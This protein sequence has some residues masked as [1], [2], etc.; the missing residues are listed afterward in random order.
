MAQKKDSQPVAVHD[1]DWNQPLSD[2]ELLGFV[3][4]HYKAAKQRRMSW[5]IGA[6]TQLAWARGDQHLRWDADMKDLVE[7]SLWM[8]E[9]IPMEHR[10][11]VALNTI[12]GQVLQKMAL[13]VSRPVTWRSRP[14][15]GD[16]ADLAAARLTTQLLQYNW[17][18]SECP[19]AGVRLMR[20]LWTMFCTG[21]IFA[22]PMWDAKLGPE[23]EFGPERNGKG[24][25]EAVLAFAETLKNRLGRDLHEGELDG[26][27]KIKLHMGEPKLQFLTGFDISE[28][29]FASDIPDC[30]WIIE[31]TWV[32]L[33]ELRTDF[34]KEKTADIQPDDDAESWTSGWRAVYGRQQEST[35][36]ETVEPS[37][38]VLMHELWRPHS[39]AAKQGFFG[40]V[41]GGQVLKSGPH[42]YKH[43][44][45]PYIRIAE[46]PDPDLFRPNCTV[47]NLM[48]LQEA[49]NRIRSAMNTYVMMRLDPKM[50]KEKSSGLPREAFSPGPRVVEVNDG[51]LTTNQ[52]KALEW[53]P[54]PIEAFRLDEMFD[55]D[56]KDVGGVHD[57]S[58]GKRQEKGESGRRVALLQGG[59]ARMNGITR[60]LVE[61]GLSEAGQQ[62][63]LL[64]WQFG[65]ENRIVGL[66]KG[67]RTET[68]RFKSS[69][70]MHQGGGKNKSKVPLLMVEV[71]IE[72]EPDIES[73]LKTVEVLAKLKFLDP[74]NP[75]DERR[76]RRLLGDRL[77]RETDEDTR[78]R[79]NAMDENEIMVLGKSPTMAIGDWDQQHVDEHMVFTTNEQFRDAVKRKSE[80]G[81]IFESH[82]RQHQYQMAQKRI[83]PKI[84]DEI[85][86]RTET[87]RIER[88]M[89][90]AGLQI[91]PGGEGGGAR[92][93]GAVAGAP[94]AA[95]RQ[96]QVRPAALPAGVN[97][98]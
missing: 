40:V 61:R 71:D 62:M 80:I 17:F 81:R 52:I 88:A 95:T 50:A 64:W 53:G 68:V 22:K 59:D 60:E 89:A 42:P 92:G 70:L 97:I 48:K 26:S 91:V 11:P 84:V 66:T 32:P 86:T 75:A 31:S 18:N 43:G 13:L 74:G 10:L 12:K 34:G 65:G 54:I 37:T 1:I 41:A 51:A 2:E 28:P 39:D 93:Q 87:V 25:K 69:A 6:A 56:I 8:P 16:D 15:T 57:A 30:A 96:T 23:Q 49:R 73:E 45:L 55:Q 90:E 77:V 14:I 3:D 4:V 35:E 36:G 44:K 29:V 5:E 79:A 72:V 7:T 85:V 27:G 21:V 33:E 58:L 76:V 82:I 67:P 83:R 78:Q 47:S 46:M 20:A 19:I 94:A 24:V 98:Q 63:I 38:H 9:H